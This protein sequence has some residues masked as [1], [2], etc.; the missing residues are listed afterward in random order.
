MNKTRRRKQRARRRDS[1]IVRVVISR[2][3]NEATDVDGVIRR[4][5]ETSTR[6]MTRKMARAFVP[7]HEVEL[8]GPHSQESDYARMMYE[9]SISKVPA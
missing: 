8:T 9:A 4:H 6:W 2:H 5:G 1:E 3:Y 7:S